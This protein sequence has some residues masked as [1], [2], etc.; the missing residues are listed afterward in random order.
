MAQTPADRT[1]IDD[2]RSNL[3]RLPYYGVFD[4]LAF[5]YEKGT[6]TLSGYSYQPLLKSDA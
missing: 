5:S 2:I 4:F 6:V 3:L 1:T